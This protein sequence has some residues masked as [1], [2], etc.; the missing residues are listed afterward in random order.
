M[1]TPFRSSEYN[2]DFSLNLRDVTWAEDD[3]DGSA[4]K[5]GWSCQCEH[6]S[7]ERFGSMYDSV[8]MHL[9]VL[10]GYWCHGYHVDWYNRIQGKPVKPVPY[11]VVH[12]LQ[13]LA[14]IPVRNIV[15]EI[16]ISITR[17]CQTFISTFESSLVH[18][19]KS[20]PSAKHCRPAKRVPRRCCTVV[21]F[22][23]ASHTKELTSGQY[24]LIFY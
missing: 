19:L 20:L 24:C 17:I 2:N 3:E 22:C 8:P 10:G 13:L 12:S 1:L 18:C 15:W 4:V 6:R 14:N 16:E 9:L 21:S 5:V 7:S 11:P 23:V